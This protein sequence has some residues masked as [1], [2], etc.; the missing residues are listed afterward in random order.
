M[1]TGQQEQPQS[2]ATDEVAARATDGILGPNPLVGLRPED[3]VAAA[4]EIGTM[5]LSQPMLL[6][7]QEAALARELLSVLSGT[8][9]LAAPAG[10]KRFADSAWRDNPFYRMYMQSYLAWGSTLGSLVEK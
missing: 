5:A 3:I 4:R 1:T 6:L 9:K 2:A 7:E 8:T 10:D